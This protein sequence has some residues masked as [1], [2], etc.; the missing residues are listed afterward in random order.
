VRFAGGLAPREVAARMRGSA[1]LVL[2]SRRESFGGVLVEAL[3]CG[4]PVVATRCGGPEEIVTPEL[5]S[6]APVEDPPALASA[7]ADVL[8]RRASFRPE[9]LREAAVG[10]YGMAATAERL[11]AIYDEVLGAERIADPI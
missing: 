2:P 8:A 5:G 7:I 3:A 1:L 10:S 9:C 11:R 4:T 6:L